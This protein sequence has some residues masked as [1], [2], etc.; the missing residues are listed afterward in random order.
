MRSSGEEAR[1]GGERASPPRRRR[2]ILPALWLGGSRGALAPARAPASP[3]HKHRA[4]F[5]ATAISGPRRDPSAK[6]PASLPQSSDERGRGNHSE[7]RHRSQVGRG[8][9]ELK[10]QQTP[11]RAR[12]WRGILRRRGTR[13]AISS[14]SPYVS[15]FEFSNIIYSLQYS[16]S[17]I[18]RDCVDTTHKC[19]CRYC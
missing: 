15:Y 13:L 16:T 10:G 11:G 3:A 2:T 8:E 12:A 7:L 6:A 4:S 18:K 1:A 17:G 9:G 14:R 5:A 19:M